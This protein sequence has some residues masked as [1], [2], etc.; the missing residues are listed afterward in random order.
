M[1]NYEEDY[2]SPRDQIKVEEF[3]TRYNKCVEELNNL[4]SKVEIL[5]GEATVSMAKLDENFENL[6]VPR[7]VLM[8][9]FSKIHTGLSDELQELSDMCLNLR[10]LVVS[11][12]FHVMDKLGTLKSDDE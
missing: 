7:K 9:E 12:N 4:L 1:P 6:D 11:T 3:S 8:K 10:T 5:K 2:Y